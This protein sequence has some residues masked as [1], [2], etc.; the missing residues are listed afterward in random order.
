MEI[1]QKLGR[2]FRGKNRINSQIYACHPAVLL[3]YWVG[4]FVFVFM[5]KHP[6]FVWT[7]F[8][9]IVLLMFLY[10]APHRIVRSG[11]GFLFLALFSLV[12]NP[13]TY[14]RGSHI[15]FY[16]FDN[17]ITLEAFAYGGYIAVMLVSLLC[18]FLVLNE[19]ID[20]A[21]FLYLF[22]K[23]FPRISF[24]LS[25]SIR[26]MDVF[27]KRAH[28]LLE[29]DATRDN[30][31]GKMRIID[32]IQKNGILLCA[33]VRWCLEEGMMIA[34]VLKAK[35]YGEKKRT[36]YCAYQWSV[37]DSVLALCLG[38]SLGISL[39]FLNKGGGYYR[40]YPRL[41]PLG[42]SKVDWFSYGAMA[43]FLSIPLLFEGI[44]TLQRRRN[45]KI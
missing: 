34:D 7:N 40:F 22:G 5:S 42:F 32:K 28:T 36:N 21:K 8:G 39:L 10:V 26:F 15:L 45:R 12:V 4:V 35:R 44:C 25:M 38:V 30:A 41:M 16:L 13:L 37:T 31:A 29:V 2:G 33:L 3:L 6:V 19:W 1:Y 20:D 17:P 18:A 14:H 23:Y 27:R 11:K 9:C 24:I 43:L